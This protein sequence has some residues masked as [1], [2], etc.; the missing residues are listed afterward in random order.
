MDEFI[1]NPMRE[2]KQRRSKRGASTNGETEASADDW[3]SDC[4]LP[5]HLN[6]KDI[7]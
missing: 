3:L 2:G 7:T 5:L 6:E 4:H 1:E